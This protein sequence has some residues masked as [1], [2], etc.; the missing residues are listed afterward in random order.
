MVLNKRSLNA[1]GDFQRQ[2]EQV[3]TRKTSGFRHT[4]PK[5]NTVHVYICYTIRDVKIG[6]SSKEYVEC[7]FAKLKERRKDEPTIFIQH[8]RNV[9]F[10]II[11]TYNYSKFSGFVTIK[12]LMMKYEVNVKFQIG[13]P[14]Y[15]E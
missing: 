8:S 5:K 14:L 13:N 3:D 10:H 12:G 11:H 4:L 15:D 1:K 2:F 6:L 9:S 7:F